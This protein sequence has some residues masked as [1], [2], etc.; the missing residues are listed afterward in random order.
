MVLGVEIRVLRTVVWNRE[1]QKLD[2]K[3]HK[4]DCTSLAATAEEAKKMPAPAA[5]SKRT[6]KGRAMASHVQKV[7]DEALKPD[8]SG[9]KS[10]TVAVRRSDRRYRF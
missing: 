3:K 1:H 8:S 7:R 6:K 5:P 10:D 2:W 9:T 4:A